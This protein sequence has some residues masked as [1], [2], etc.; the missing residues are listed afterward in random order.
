MS[1]SSVFAVK[2]QGAA[3]K[4]IFFPCGAEKRETGYRRQQQKR[5]VG[6]VELNEGSGRESPIRS[7][8]CHWDLHVVRLGVSTPHLYLPVSSFCPSSSDPLHSVHT[9][10]SLKAYAPLP[11]MALPLS[12][13]S[14]SSASAFLGPLVQTA[15]SI[16]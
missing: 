3:G 10:G 13:C 5:T 15:D 14:L 11:E 1:G 4:M 12:P 9:L 6:K 2:E 7:G 8:G 16:T